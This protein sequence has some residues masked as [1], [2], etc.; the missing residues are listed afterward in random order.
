MKLFQ[1]LFTIAL[2]FALV[3]PVVADAQFQTGFPPQQGNSG[4]VLQTDGLN[5]EWV[6]P[7]NL[8]G[9]SA[10]LD[11]VGNNSTTAGDSLYTLTSGVPVIFEDSGNSPI[12]ELDESLGA[13]TIGGS[14]TLPTN[15]GSSGQ[16][17]QTDGAGNVTFQPGGSAALDLYDENFNAAQGFNVSITGD[18]AV[19]IGGTITG[20]NTVTGQDSIV[21]GGGDNDVD[22]LASAVLG[23]QANQANL[24]NATVMGGINNEIDGQESSIT[25]GVGNNITGQGNAIMGGSNN[26][27][28]N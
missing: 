15:D 6:S 27:I 24:S 12:L 7:G 28:N 13:L 19:G 25:G 26:T 3:I 23:G 16:V 9:S 10:T 1:R 21:L 18:N 8:G 20:Q 22:G 14:Y 4:N 2:A 5:M 17:L 11:D